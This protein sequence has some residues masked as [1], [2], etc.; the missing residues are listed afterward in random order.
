MSNNRIEFDSMGNIEV[1][2]NAYY[3]AQTQRAVQNFNISGHNLPIQF[4]YAIARI[5]RA[6]AYVNCDLGLLD[7]LRANSI[8]IAADSI[9][10]G[11]HNDHFPID[12]FQ[13]GSGTSS[14]MNVNEVISYL[15]Y[16][17]KIKISANDHVNM[18]QSSNDTIPSAINISSVLEI[19]GRLLPALRHIHNVIIYKAKYVDDVVKT[20]RTHLMDAMPIR[21][22]QELYGWAEQVNQSIERIEHCLISFM[23]ISQGGT[24]VGTGINAHPKFASNIIDK[25]SEDTGLCFKLC[26]N[27]FAN[28]SSQDTSV[29]MSGHLKAFA[30]ALMK[31]SN[32][33]RLMNSGP[34]SGFSEIEIEALQPGSSI[35]PGKVNPVIPETAAQVAAQVIGNDTVITIGGQSGNFQLNVMLPLIANNLLESITILSNVTI[36]LADKCI[37]TF[38]IHREKIKAPINKNPVLITALNTI[39]GYEKSSKIAN[40]AYKNGRFIIDVAHEDTNFSRVALEC[41]LDPAKLTLGG[42]PSIKK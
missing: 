28:Q 32:D 12:V 34:I 2:A 29:E 3:G 4:I 42:I 17:E 26:K 11:N 39:I 18:S 27:F 21:M 19:N 20:G 25:L 35:M 30:C 36:L 24:A 33:L 1:P 40:K 31:I 14:N 22:S 16:S 10:A 5:K 6:A 8:I 23:N 7:K 37:K 41:Y 38:K 13:T 15:A 9:I